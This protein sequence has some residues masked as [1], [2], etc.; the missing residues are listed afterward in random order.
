MSI[1]LSYTV[2]HSVAAP[3]PLKSNKAFAVSL[4]MTKESGN[5]SVQTVDHYSTDFMSSR[6]PFIAVIDTWITVAVE[7]H[8]K[9][10]N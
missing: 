2:S 7:T 8:T 6:H 10:G 1:T 5:N 3:D 4:T 9:Y